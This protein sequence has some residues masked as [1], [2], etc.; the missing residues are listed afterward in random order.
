VGN[1]T[2]SRY[3][4]A[5]LRFVDDMGYTTGEL[6]KGTSTHN[7]DDYPLTEIPSILVGKPF[8]KFVGGRNGSV[9]FEFVTRGK[10]FILAQ[11]WPGYPQQAT[12]LST[13]AK[14]EDMSVRN[15]KITFEV[16]SITAEAGKRVYLPFQEI[17]VADHLE[18][19][20]KLN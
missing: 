12:I 3:P 4:L 8:T 2:T 16:W 19:V 17:L 9:S 13:L 20:A 14:K 11:V 5:S 18:K 1:S 7:N 10:I 6:H 15:T